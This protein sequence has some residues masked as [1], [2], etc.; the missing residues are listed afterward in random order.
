MLDDDHP[1]A[2]RRLND[3]D[4]FAREHGGWTAL[5]V[6]DD[7]RGATPA[8]PL[9]EPVVAVISHA[10]E[11]VRLNFGEAIY[12]MRS[13]DAAAWARELLAAGEA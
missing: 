5:L 3:F 4:A 9:M 2:T 10:S 12:L 7:E 1:D 8:D 11:M 6:H 13:A